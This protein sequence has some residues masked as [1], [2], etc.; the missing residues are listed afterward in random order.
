MRR[1]LGLDAIPSPRSSGSTGLHPAL[2]APPPRGRPHPRARLRLQGGDPDQAGRD[3]RPGRGGPRRPRRVAAG[4]REQA[5]GAPDRWPATRAWSPRGAGS[6]G[7]PDER[8]ER[9]HR[10]RRPPRPHGR[11]PARPAG[12]ARGRLRGGGRPR[13][14][15]RAPSTSTATR[16]TASTTSSCRPTT[17]SSASPTSSASASDLRLRPLGR[18]L[19]PRRPALLDVDAAGVPHLPAPAHARPPAPRGL[20]RL[21]PAPREPGGPRQMP[22]EAWLEERCGRRT[23]ERLWRPLLDSKFDGRYD[24]LPATYL[25]ARTRRMS[26]HP[27]ARPRDHGLDPGRLPDADRGLRARIEQ[28][29]GEVHA[30]TR[31]E[32]ITGDARDGAT[33]LVVDGVHRA[34]DAVASTLLPPQARALLDP[35]LRELAAGGP[36]PLPR[37]RLRRAAGGRLGEPLLLAQRH[38]PQHPAHDRGRD[39]PRRGPRARRRHPH[40]RRALREPGQPGPRRATPTRSPTTTSRT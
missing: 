27:R 31:V 14:P 7:R 28:F 29:G 6:R 30:G 21:V 38:R 36:L 11:L 35:E 8:P 25:W 33:G 13:R 24:D 18:R 37:R 23:A 4:G 17:A 10:R 34:F 1:A 15:R 20:R 40:L 2:A 16:S 9:R 39:D 12:R 19:L 22:L 26:A 3:G 32:R 5:A